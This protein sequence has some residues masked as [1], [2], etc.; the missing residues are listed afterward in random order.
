[1]AERFVFL[2]K[3]SLA[4]IGLDE[5]AVT[6]VNS[7]PAFAR[8]KVHARPSTWQLLDR[9]EDTFT[10]DWASNQSFAEWR[11]NLDKMLPGIGSVKMLRAQSSSA[12]VLRGDGT[13]VGGGNGH[14]WIKVADAA[15]AERTR[16]AILARALE[17]DLAWTK[18]RMSKSTGQECGRGFATIVDPSVWTVGRFVFVGH[19]TC[20]AGLTVAPQQ[21]EHIDG[22]AEALDTSQSV[23]SVLKTYRASA[24]QGVP[25]RLKRNG[26]G[27]G[28][29]TH[30]LR[31]DT[32]IVLADGSV[33][34][35]RDLIPALTEKIRC[36]APFRES[37]SLAAFIAFDGNGEPFVFDSG[38]GTKH[39]LAE[40]DG[41]WDGQ[42]GS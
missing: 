28:S 23:V 34:T 36:Q 10:P 35:V 17:H 9:D 19:P 33:K 1:M 42:Q 22:D 31:P 39:V 6:T 26:T 11:L 14:V 37:S 4:D 2:S 38:T 12:R 18:P 8:L 40:P 41:C 30:D 16:T 32:E 15:D 25:L 5:E 7:M 13:A 3:K 24:R 21:F 29:V 20:S 27:Y